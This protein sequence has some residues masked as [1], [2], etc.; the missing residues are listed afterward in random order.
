MATDPSTLAGFL[1]VLPELLLAVGALVLL[2]IGAFGGERTTPAVTGFAIALVVAAA[3]GLLLIPADA[4]MFNG[5]FALDP[6]ARHC[7]M[8]GID[9]LGLLLGQ[10]DAIA[11]YEKKAEALS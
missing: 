3:V 5:A 4:K 2:M 10:L 11:A 7:L 8:A 6:F 9:E 1:P